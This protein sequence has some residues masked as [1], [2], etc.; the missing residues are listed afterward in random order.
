MRADRAS[1]TESAGNTYGSG[2]TDA[3]QL[4]YYS[5]AYSFAESSIDNG[6]VLRGIAFWRW[7]AAPVL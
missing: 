4:A 3:N 2:Q 6:G 1:C 7:C 5:L